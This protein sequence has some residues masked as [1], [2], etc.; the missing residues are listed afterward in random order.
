MCAVSKTLLTN[1]IYFE[2]YFGRYFHTGDFRLCAEMKDHLSYFTSRGISIDCLFLDTTFASNFWEKVPTKVCAQRSN[3]LTIQEE[4][5][6]QILEI[7]SKHPNDVQVYIECDMLGTEEIL[8]S[9]AEKYQ[10]KVC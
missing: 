4:A 7:I 5:T 3:H 2:G 8:T 6:S 10:T 9:I 1:R